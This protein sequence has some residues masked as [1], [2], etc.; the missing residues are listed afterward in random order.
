MKSNLLLLLLAMTGAVPV[1]ACL[2]G[3]HAIERVVIKKLPA[4]PMDALSVAVQN[5]KE[6]K[7]ELPAFS[8]H[9]PFRW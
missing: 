2:N 1:M 4:I 8:T 5:Q 6:A 9:W 7:V 3:S